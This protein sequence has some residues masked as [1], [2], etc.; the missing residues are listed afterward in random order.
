MAK[1][2]LLTRKGGSKKK[3]KG[4]ADK[5]YKLEMFLPG[6]QANAKYPIDFI[7]G[8]EL[9]KARLSL[10]PA[11]IKPSIILVENNKKALDYS[12]QVKIII[13]TK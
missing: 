12:Q 2:F 1:P 13:E 9:E 4:M 8:N 3:Q 11:Q 10:T 6:S 5:K 7:N